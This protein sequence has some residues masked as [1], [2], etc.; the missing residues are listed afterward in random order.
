LLR[1]VILR[2][3]LKLKGE[4]LEEYGMNQIP[5]KCPVCGGD[6]I[7]TRLHCPACETTIEGSFSPGGS[8]LQEAFTPEQLRSLLPFARLTQEQLYF[9]LSFVRCEGRFN[10]MEEELKLSYP[11]LRSRLDEILLALGFEPD[12]EEP[13]RQEVGRIVSPADR[14][15]ILDQLN[16]GEISVEEARRRLRGEQPEPTQTNQPEE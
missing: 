6:L 2:E 16:R 5:S 4:I 7:V 12:K 10:R 11:T 13:T 3:L 1:A 14:Q 8:P 15:A 9:M